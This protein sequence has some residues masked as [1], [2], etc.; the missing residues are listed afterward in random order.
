MHLEQDEKKSLVS[1]LFFLK[2]FLISLIFIIFL[3]IAS[4]PHSL[5]T[6]E[7]N[8][9]NWID[10][11]LILDISK[12]MDATD[13]SPTRIE[14]SK[15]V[16]QKFIS[17]QNTNR[18]WLIVFSWAPF[19]WIPLTFDYE[20][21]TESIKGLNTDSL[22]WN[23][24]LFNWTAIWDAL[25]LSKSLFETIDD[26]SK[27]REKTVILLT[28]WDANKGVD[29]SLVADLLKKE[30]IKIYSIWIWSEKWSFVEINNWFFSQKVP[31][32]PLKSEWLKEMSK[33]TWWYFFN[34]KDDDTM[35][36]IFKKL[37]ELEKNDIEVEVDKIF[38]ELYSP[39]VYLALALIWILL[40]LEI[41]RVKV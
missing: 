15:Q 11:V 16:L 32:P 23:T 35:E 19:I 25:L 31:I 5:N 3:F 40:F 39:F 41:R 22:N 18:V 14:K 30:N 9:K 28:D 36:K 2:L 34:W 17:A 27:T 12:S 38:K 10:I 20:I 13:L 6:K 8:T 1:S 37:E 4:D 26:K 29:P 21:L 7:K 24:R 33:K